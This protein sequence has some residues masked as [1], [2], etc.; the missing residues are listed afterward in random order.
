MGN[1]IESLLEKQIEGLLE[2]EK[3]I[4]KF[5]TNKAGFITNSIIYLF[6]IVMFIGLYFGIENAEE[7]FTNLVNNIVNEKDTELNQKLVQLSLLFG[8]GLWQQF[9]IRCIAF[10]GGGYMLSLLINYW[11]YYALRNYPPSFILLTEEAY[12]DKEKSL[13]NRK[14]KFIS[15]IISIF[16]SVITSVIGSYIFV[17][18]FSN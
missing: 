8:E 17:K 10:L 18:Y 11:T 6:V 16:I 12:K 5:L 15:A 2:E 9:I 1:D 3:K 14:K 4:N 7:N 13:K